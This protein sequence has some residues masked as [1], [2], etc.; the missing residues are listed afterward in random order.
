MRLSSRLQ[1]IY[2]DDVKGLALRIDSSGRKA[3]YFVRKVRGKQHQFK[4]GDLAMPLKDA[5][6]VASEYAAKIAKDLDPAAERRQ[7]R[8]MQEEAKFN[9]LQAVFET[10]LNYARQHTRTWRES[11]KNFRLYVPRQLK[12]KQ[13]RDITM[14]EL[15]ALHLKIGE[16]RPYLANRVIELL[17]AVF[18]AAE[19]E[20]NPARAPG[21]GARK[22]GIKRY[23]EEPRD[24]VLS[25]DEAA[26]FFRQLE[27]ERIDLQDLV[28]LL[29]STGARRS[30]V[31]SMRW[32]DV[33]I[34]GRVWRIPMT[35]SGEA[36]LVPLVSK[37]MEILKRRH[38]SRQ[39]SP[40]VFASPSSKSGHVTNPA[41][42]WYNFLARAH[43]QDFRLHDLKHTIATAMARAGV[44]FSTIK[45]VLQHQSEGKRKGRDV[46]L[47]YLTT[48]LDDKRAGIEAGLAEIQNAALSS[49]AFANL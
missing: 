46:T 14:A 26:R 48:D 5:R 3:Y 22:R 45:R 44:T 40:Y 19:I 32:E 24:R 25:A 13:A 21:R 39:L 7:K 17:T 15:E 6:E 27:L 34:K 23:R 36:K 47:T 10:Y 9:T 49:E 4:I 1:Y 31:L 43:I 29:L 12:A 8:R 16:S 18:Y 42:A 28:W 33:D 30:N 11:E 37:S 2:D 41:K 35:K 38:K 20:P